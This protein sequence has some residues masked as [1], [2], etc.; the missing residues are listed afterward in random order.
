MAKLKILQLQQLNGPDDADVDDDDSG[1][2]RSVSM[3]EEINSSYDNQ[4]QCLSL[5]NAHRNSLG[6]ST[7]SEGIEEGGMGIKSDSNVR[8]ILANARSLLP[9]MDSLTDAFES[10]RLDFALITE[11]WFKGGKKLAQALRDVE[12]ASGIKVVHKSRDGRLS[13]GGAGGV[14]IAFNSTTTNFKQRALK[15]IGS[16]HKVV[17]AVGRMA[18]GSIRGLRS[19]ENA[20]C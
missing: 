16:T 5:T 3:N 14:A 18:C 9:K 17:C 2:N 7:S 8:F 20:S 6:S 1:T 4:A 15:H 13:G 10:L 19:P 12:G 11:T